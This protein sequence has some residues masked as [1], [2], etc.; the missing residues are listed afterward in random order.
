MK[1]SNK[2]W[3]R[4][5]ITLSKAFSFK[6]C[7]LSSA[8]NVRYWVGFQKRW[9][10]GNNL[11]CYCSRLGFTNSVQVFMGKK[12][13]DKWKERNLLRKKSQINVGERIKLFFFFLEV[14]VY[15]GCISKT[16]QKCSLRILMLAIKSRY[17]IK[18]SEL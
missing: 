12:K 6:N 1:H 8:G 10:V 2:T 13:S 17:G 4:T 9:H 11:Q 18:K 7:N 3:V 16:W 14:K 15:L 5:E